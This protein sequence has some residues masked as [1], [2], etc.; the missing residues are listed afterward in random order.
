MG[1]EGRKHG[2]GGC[3]GW[4]ADGADGGRLG[5]MEL[6]TG[7]RRLGFRPP[8]HLTFSDCDVLTQVVE[9]ERYNAQRNV[10]CRATM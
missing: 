1:A 4:G 6:C 3:G 5:R 9:L 7:L 8:I 2:C 10:I